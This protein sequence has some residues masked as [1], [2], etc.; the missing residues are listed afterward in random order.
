MIEILPIAE[1]YVDAV[2]HMHKVCFPRQQLSADWVRCNFQCY[3]RVQ[4]YVAKNSQGEIVGYIQWIQKSGF[5]QQVVLELEQ[6][7]VLPEYQGQGMGYALITKSLPMVQ[8]ELQARGASL[9]HILVTTRAD[10]QSQR[11]YKKALNAEIEAVISNLYSHDE[12]IM[13]ARD[14]D[15]LMSPS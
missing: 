9:K 14:V 11:L 3:P 1:A 7:A 2:A 5:R 15:V 12:V 8:R 10:N 13:V 6:F 4:L